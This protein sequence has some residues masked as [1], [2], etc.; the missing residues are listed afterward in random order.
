MSPPNLMMIGPQGAGKGTQSNLLAESFGYQIIGIGKILRDR[1]SQKNVLGKKI[2]RLLDHGELVND[3]VIEEIIREKLAHIPPGQALIFD[4][5]PRTLHQA[6]LLERIFL[7][8][9][10]SRPIALYLQLP[11]SLI[12]ARLV[13][14]REC[15]DCGTI[16]KFIPKLFTSLLCPKCGGQM[17]ARSDDRPE[18]IEARLNIFYSHTF[19]VIDYYQ[20]LNRLIE[21]DAAGTIEEVAAQ[22]EHRLNLPHRETTHVTPHQDASPN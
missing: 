13:H 21:I 16:F 7:A 1:A 4:G 10:R 22:I 20:R 15:S 3:T 8:Q 6:H 17:N 12:V 14:R 19:P 2:K 18:V 11:R 9:N 5:F